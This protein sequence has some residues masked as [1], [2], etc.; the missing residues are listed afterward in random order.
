MGTG[1]SA[2][3]IRSSAIVVQVHIYNIC[4][5]DASD[6]N[7]RQNSLSKRERREK[8]VQSTR[9]LSECDSQWGSDGNEALA[10]AR[11]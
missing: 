4:D 3:N 2:I 10:G 8:S 5:S 1:S 9:I 11:Q 6:L 7:L